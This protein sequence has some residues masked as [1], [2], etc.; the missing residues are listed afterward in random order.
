[1]PVKVIGPDGAE[2]Q[3]PDGTDKPAAIAYFKKKGIGGKPL[4][5]AGSPP[6][7][8]GILEGIERGKNDVINVFRPLSA[9]ERGGIES[10]MG[11]YPGAAFEGVSNATLGVASAGATLLLHPL[12][13]IYGTAQM[14]ADALNQIFPDAGLNPRQ[15]AAKQA[16][17]D[18]LKSQWEQIKENPDYA[19]G[20]I[21]GG[22]EAGRAMG[23]VV[24]PVTKGLME[25]AGKLREGL[26]GTAQSLAGAG[27]KV[28]EEQVG[29]TAKSAGESAKTTEANN[30]A[31]LSKYEQDLR[32]AAQKNVNAHV[33]YLADKA[34]AEQ[35]NAAAKAIPDARAGLESY[36]DNKLEEADVRTEKARHDALEVGNEKYS[37]VNSELDWY[38]AD[39]EKTR[40]ALADATKSISGDKMPPLVKE[41]DERLNGRGVDGMPRGAMT[42]DELQGFYSKL[43]PL[44]S[45]GTLEGET[46]HAYDI[47]HDAVGDEMQ[48]IADDHGQG[49]ALK[50]AR[51]YWRRMKQTFGKS[52]DII[53]N[54]AGKAVSGRASDYTDRQADEYTLRLLDSFDPGI[55][56]LL[57][58]V[59][60]ANE[61]LS[62]LP[63]DATRPKVETPT[64]PEEKPVEPP[65]T[66][67]VEVPEVNTRA[68][69]E[70]LV[71]KWARGESG[72]NKFQV[73]RLIGSAGVG[74][75]IGAVFGHGFGAEVG[76]AVGT[77]AYALS[78]AILAKIIS[79]PGVMEF[80]SR[81]PA[82]EIDALAK[83]PYADRIK[84]TD[85]LKQV[86]QAAQR[87]G[88]KV[89]PTLA[90]LIGATAV[91]GPKTKKL[92][93]DA[94]YYRTH[95][96]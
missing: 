44:L 69:R 85:G 31:A 83:L 50:D 54:R 75:I 60:A 64:Y 3:F 80:L 56:P 26:R 47:L 29:T 36:V 11:K 8:P 62:K 87:K 73:A 43:G 63:T 46:Y 48:R 58:D 70:E 13:S 66:K 18:R 76:S 65:K 84:L 42:Y 23:E 88:I 27:R 30:R 24:G 52:S 72:L 90:A 37:G 93:Q 34:D 61:R 96:R 71:R 1:M 32:E 41:F 16:S 78:P 17:L 25:K 40:K 33:K 10:T 95:A 20:N 82:G 35:T 89:S 55:S 53:N 14:A 57:R 51:N 22:I 49:A 94:E 2:Y 59:D 5:E 15:K 74:T 45:K 92:Q 7:S 38:E 79:H 67:A 91:R 68:L 39:P 4:S 21:L 86:A 9:E 77:A 28:V 12:S 81:P 6:E 19:M